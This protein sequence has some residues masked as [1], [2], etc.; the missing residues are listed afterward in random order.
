MGT[1][2]RALLILI[3]IGLAAMLF[4]LAKL[5]K[6]VSELDARLSALEVETDASLK[7]LL[8]ARQA[9]EPKAQKEVDER[10]EAAP[11]ESEQLKVFSG[12]ISNKGLCGAFDELGKRGDILCAHA[13]RILHW[14]LDLRKDLRRGDEIAIVYSW[15]KGEHEPTIEALRFAGKVKVRAHRFK[16]GEDEHASYFDERGVEIPARLVNSPIEGYEQI[17]AFFGERRGR[18]KHMGIDFKAPVGTPVRSPFAGAVVRKNWNWRSNGNC[19]EIKVDGQAL[20][21][22]F[23]HL[24]KIDVDVGDRVEK[25]QVITRSGNTGKT[26]APHLHYQLDVVKGGKRMSIDPLKYH[27]LYRKTLEGEELEAFHAQVEKLQALMN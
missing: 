27:E 6:R 9:M 22:I 20:Y 1:H 2:A 14:K 11:H 4:H 15:P 25:G 3:L 17:T 7:K 26:T 24:D 23:L 8:Q 5:S 10:T 21:V 16:A 19:L 13:A 18:K 12:T